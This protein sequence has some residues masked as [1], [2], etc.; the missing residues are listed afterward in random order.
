MREKKIDVSKNFTSL[1]SFTYSL[2]ELIDLIVHT[3]ETD[4]KKSVGI[5]DRNLYILRKNGDVLSLEEQ[6]NISYLFN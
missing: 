4:L 3:M 1:K 6:G 2:Q 5:L